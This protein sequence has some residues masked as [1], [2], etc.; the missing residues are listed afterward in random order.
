MLRKL[1]A[2]NRNL[3]RNGLTLSIDLEAAEALSD[4][5]L[6]RAVRDTGHALVVE[7]QALREQ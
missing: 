5:D 2:L 4:D 3:E 1:A 7:T 6:E